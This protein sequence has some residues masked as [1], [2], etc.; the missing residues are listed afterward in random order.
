MF[1][2]EWGFQLEFVRVSVWVC[3]WREAGSASAGAPGDPVAWTTQRRADQP[4]TRAGHARH[5]R[6]GPN[7]HNLCQSLVSTV[8]VTEICE[9]LYIY[10]RYDRILKC[11]P[12]SQI[13]PS[14][15]LLTDSTLT[16][17]PYPSHPIHSLQS[18]SLSSTHSS[19]YSYPSPLTPLF[20]LSLVCCW[21]MHFGKYCFKIN[22]IGLQSIRIWH[23]YFVRYSTLFQFSWNVHKWVFLNLA[24]FL[25]PRSYNQAG[26]VRNFW[27]D[28]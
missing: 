10:S 25:N 28:L 14:L 13:N 16:N 24:V 27:I 17:I 18:S 22:N 9:T 7:R 3:R 11:P 1:Q 23:P 12:H 15:S 19:R 6:P 21:L 20:I 5:P 8:V 4:H 2:V 26:W